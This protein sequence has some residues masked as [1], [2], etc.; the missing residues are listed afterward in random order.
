MADDFHRRGCVLRSR[1]PTRG[2]AGALPAV[3]SWALRTKE[4]RLQELADGAFLDPAECFYEQGQPLSIR[5]MP[6]HVRRAIAS[7][8]V[9]AEKFVTKVKFVDKRGA[10]M[11][12]PNYWGMSR[13][14][15]RNIAWFR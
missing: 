15:K 4:Q 6:E 12:I 1:I 5:A 13:T 11:I 9:D 7:Y 10:I 3:A 8:E 14:P 2:N